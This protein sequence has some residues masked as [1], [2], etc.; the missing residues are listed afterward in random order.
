M[1]FTT[2][3]KVVQTIVDMMMT[4]RGLR[5]LPMPSACII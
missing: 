4:S 2:E 1:T 3:P 5:R